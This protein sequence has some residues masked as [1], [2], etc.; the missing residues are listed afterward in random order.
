MVDIKELFEYNWHC[1]R[2]FLESFEKL[3]WDEVVADRGASFGSMR[4]IFLHSMAAEH[5]WLRHLARGKMGE[6]SDFDPDRDFKDIA[7]IGKYVEKVEADDRVYLYKLGPADLSKPFPLRAREGT[8]GV[9]KVE[10]ILMHVVEEEIHHRG[11]LLCLMWQIDVEPPYNDYI[12]YIIE[13]KK[14]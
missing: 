7:A 14:K 3:P 10:D 13:K 5:D 12:D 9:L 4:D 6:W 2:K 1:R 8:D 11:E